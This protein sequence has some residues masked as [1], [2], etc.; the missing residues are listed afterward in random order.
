MA[1]AASLARHDMAVTVHERA[2]QLRELGAGIYLKENSLRVLDRLGIYEPLEVRAVRLAKGEIRTEG[3]RLVMTRRLVGE[4]A[5]VALRSDL[6]ALLTQAA[7]TEGATILT[8]SAVQ[9]ADP[10]GSV[11]LQDGSGTEP[12]EL[13]VGADGL[14]SRVRVTA[15]IGGR[16]RNLADGATRLLIERREPEAVSTEYWSGKLRVGVTPCSPEHTYVFLIAPETDERARSVPVNV[17]YW[18]HH[19]PY[20]RG[21]MERIDAG[22]ATHHRHALVLCKHW[23]RGKVALVGDSAHAQPPNLGQGAGLA[24]ANAW[25][26]AE[27]VQS[28]TDVERG[29]TVWEATNRPI[30]HQVQRWSYRYG[31]A[32]YRWPPRS[33]GLRSAALWT[34]GHV[35]YTGRRWNR[36]WRGGV[37]VSPGANSG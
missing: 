24:I 20:L 16:V 4:R 26:L 3:G 19:F 18:L 27:A 35:P 36:L 9:A 37:S 34:L 13:V 11:I 21:V 28:H 12:A 6:H 25:S 14:Y 23:A 31:L 8:R 22:V 29:L 32:G 17:E 30:A 33:Y 2:P 10:R 5:L 15:G 7:E 1:V